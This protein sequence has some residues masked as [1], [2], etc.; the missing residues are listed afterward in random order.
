M[1]IVK[2]QRSQALCT[3]ALDCD[4]EGDE[5]AVDYGPSAGFVRGTAG[6]GTPDGQ[7]REAGQGQDGTDKR[8][9]VGCGMEEGWVLLDYQVRQFRIT[10]VACLARYKWR[11][12]GSGGGRRRKCLELRAVYKVLFFAR[13]GVDD[14]W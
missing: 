12:G 3:A 6:L 10:S 11:A 14:R 7:V 1:H 8:G 13:P 9:N 2:L 4:A 5:R